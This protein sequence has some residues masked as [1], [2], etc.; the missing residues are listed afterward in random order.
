MA[1]RRKEREIK[2]VTKHKRQ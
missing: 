2:K 1:I